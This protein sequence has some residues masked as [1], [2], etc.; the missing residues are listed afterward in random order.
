LREMLVGVSLS[1]TK[2]GQVELKS[3]PVHSSAHHNTI[4]VE[5]AGWRQPVS[6]KNGSG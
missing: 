1:V 2:T 6:D 5:Y 4:F 3:G